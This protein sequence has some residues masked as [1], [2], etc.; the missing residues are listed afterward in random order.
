MNHFNLTDNLA[1]SELAELMTDHHFMLGEQHPA[2]F[3][4][5]IQDMKQYR[6]DLD[7]HQCW[8]VLRYCF[9]QYDATDLN[10]SVI[11]SIAVLFYGPAA[12]KKIDQPAT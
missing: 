9:S 11:S 2:A 10:W 6:P 5:E 7:D 1:D 4:L 8:E 12:E 3:T